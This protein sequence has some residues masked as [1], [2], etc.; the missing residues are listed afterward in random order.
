MSDFDQF[1]SAEQ[2]PKQ[3]EDPAAD[4]LA[5]EQDQFAELDAV[6]GD[7]DNFGGMADPAAAAPAMPVQGGLDLGLHG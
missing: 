2:P 7:D 6:I 1:E 4:F 3:E 5:R